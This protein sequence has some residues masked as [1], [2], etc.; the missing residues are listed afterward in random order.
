MKKKNNRLG[1]ELIMVLFVFFSLIIVLLLA[2][3]YFTHSREVDNLYQDR[4]ARVSVTTAS[5]LDGDYL[6][7][8]RETAA[9]QEY[10]ELRKSADSHSTGYNA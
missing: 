10:Q 2:G 5:L 4:A 3:S 6:E 7:K 1:K 8:L 9:S